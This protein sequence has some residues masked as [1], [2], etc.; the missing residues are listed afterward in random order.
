[1][2]RMYLWALNAENGKVYVTEVPEDYSPEDC[3][4]YLTKKHKSLDAIEWMLSESSEAV[5]DLKKIGRG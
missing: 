5:R 3:E 2:G 1:M 4:A